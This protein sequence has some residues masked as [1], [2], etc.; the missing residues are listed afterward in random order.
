M[1]YTTGV[2]LVAIVLAN[3][4]SSPSDDGCDGE[5]S[6]PER[7]TVM[8][9]EDA[10]PTLLQLRAR[11]VDAGA[12]LRL[13]IILRTR[14][15][16]IGSRLEAS[17]DTWMKEVSPEDRVITVAS[18]PL[19]ARSRSANKTGLKLSLEGVPITPIDCPDSHNVGLN[20]EM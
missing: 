19:F 14:Y 6:S 5:L 15:E 4:Q 13:L 2:A 16:N 20:C 17:R 8:A 1:R 18:D 9:G 11:K 3:L 10:Q 7:S 12:N